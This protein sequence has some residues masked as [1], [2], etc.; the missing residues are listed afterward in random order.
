MFLLGLFGGNDYVFVF[1]LQAQAVEDAHVDVR[2]PDQRKPGDEVAAPAWVEQVE[3]REDEEE[4]SD[5]VR[6]AVFA[7]EEVEEFADEHGSVVFCFALAELAWFAEDLFV[8]DG[9]GG[10]GDRQGEEQEVSE[11]GSEERHLVGE[12][13]V[14]AWA[15]RRRILGWIGRANAFAQFLRTH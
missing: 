7:G 8:G 13:R 10:A 5:I 15:I 14:A 2:D 6:E 1:D 11:L 4:G 3:A 12:M 9:P